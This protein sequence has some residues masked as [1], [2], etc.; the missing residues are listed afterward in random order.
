MQLLR[1]RPAPP[2][3][4]FI[5]C[6]WWSQRDEPQPDGEH[7]LPAGGAQLLFALHETPIACRSSGAAAGRTWTGSI[8]HGP[9][10]SYY[11]AG[12]KPAGGVV[13]VSFRP[14]AAGALLGVPLAELT[15]RHVSLDAIWGARAVD[16]RQRLLSAAEPSARFRILEQALSARLHRPLLIHPAVARALAAQGADIA[17]VAEL[18]RA[19]G[20]SPKHFIALFRGAVGLNPKLYYRI[21]RFA[22]AARSLAAGGALGDIAAAAGYADQA[23]LTRDFREFAGVTPTAYRPGG[24]DRPLHHRGAPLASRS[25]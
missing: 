11:L 10:S 23:H 17:R 3:D 15:D 16:L 5:E 9:Q 1:H 12:P 20:Y 2:L 25:R 21:R 24:S 14:G 19:S 6:L 8:V 4:R 7:M 18:Q 22:A 13:G